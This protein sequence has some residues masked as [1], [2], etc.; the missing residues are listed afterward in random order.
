MKAIFTQDKKRM[1]FFDMNR[2]L[3]DERATFNECFAQALEDF[4][5]RWEGG[6]DAVQVT[7]TYWTEWRKTADS[8]MPVKARRMQCLARALKPYPIAVNDSFYT[9]LFSRID[10]LKA[11]RPRLFPETMRTLEALAPHYG[12]AIISN[13]GKKYLENQVS[14]LGLAGLFPKEWQ[15]AGFGKETR[16]PNPA[17]FRK[18]LQET[19][20]SATQAVMVGNS[21]KNDIYGATRCGI[22]GV[23]LNPAHRKKMSQRRVGKEKVVVVRKIGQ[24]LDIFE[25]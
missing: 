13:S 4:A 14:R 19:G 6:I 18:A 12:L 2:T 21:W 7:E 15:F 24:L 8:G 11:S 17:I 23:W 22:D 10:E 25:H 20:V 16:K 3:L 1:I 9:Q 5:G